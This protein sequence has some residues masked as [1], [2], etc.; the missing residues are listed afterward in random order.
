MFNHAR[1]H[2]ETMTNPNDK[3]GE[4]TKREGFEMAAMQGMTVSHA[5]KIDNIMA[6][7][8]VELADALIAEL[9]REEGK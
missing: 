8:C 5:W 4:M 1:M 3:A 9:N 2:K 7:R 6:Q